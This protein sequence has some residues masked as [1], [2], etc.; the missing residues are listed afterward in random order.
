MIFGSVS[1][2]QSTSGSKSSQS[3]SPLTGVSN[4]LSS[5]NLMAQLQ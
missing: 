5:E 3:E 4:S 2:A 1:F